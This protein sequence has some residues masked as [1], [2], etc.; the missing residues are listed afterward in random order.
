VYGRSFHRL[1]GRGHVPQVPQWHDIYM[2]S[3]TIRHLSH[4]RQW[5]DRVERTDW[6]SVS[7]EFASGAAFR[8]DVGRPVDWTSVGG[9]VQSLEGVPRQ[10]L[11]ILDVVAASCTRRR[12]LDPDD[13]NFLDR[14]CSTYTSPAST[15][16]KRYVITNFSTIH[17]PRHQI[18]SNQIWISIAHLQCL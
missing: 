7:A 11:I 16:I 8:V 9:G 6:L 14:S 4:C 2:Y 3:H 5:F 12:P 18:K 10:R 17:K 15:C 13:D 1:V